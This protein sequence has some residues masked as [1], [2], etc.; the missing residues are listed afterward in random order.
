MNAKKLA[1]LTG[2]AKDTLRYYEKIGLITTP[3]RNDNG[4]RIYTKAHIKEIK[5]IKMAQ[6]VGFTLSTIK[7]AVP[8]LANPDPS[9]PVLKQ[10]IKDQM[11]AIDDKIREL[12]QAKGTLSS[13]LEMT[14]P[15]ASQQ[16][17]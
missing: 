9:C 13:W 10:T 8:K 2:T 5:F 17:D 12:N 7:E 4:Y 3:K 11:D 14:S 1:E 6:S 16:T 15:K